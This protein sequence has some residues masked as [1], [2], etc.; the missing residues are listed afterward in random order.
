MNQVIVL[1][2]ADDT[3]VLPAGNVINL[4][5]GGDGFNDFFGPGMAG[6]A[7][8]AGAAETASG[9]TWTDLTT[10]VEQ[11]TVPFLNDTI[12]LPGSN[13]TFVY[14]SGLSSGNVTN[15][16]FFGGGENDFFGSVFPQ[17][18]TAWSDSAVAAGNAD[19][20]LSIPTES[21]PTDATVLT[22]SADTIVFPLFNTINFP[23][24]GVGENNFFGGG[25]GGDGGVGTGIGAGSS[26]AATA[27]ETAAATSATGTA[28]NTL[29]LSADPSA[30]TAT[31]DTFSPGAGE[32]IF[33]PSYN[34]VNLPF[35][36][37]GENDFFGG[38]DGG[39]GGNGTGIGTGGIGSGDTAGTGIGIGGAGGD[40]GN[41]AQFFPVHV[42]FTDSSGTGATISADSS[43]ATSDTSA[44]SL[45]S[46]L[47]G[48]L[49]SSGSSSVGVA[50]GTGIGIGGPGGDGG[51]GAE[52]LPVNL[53]VNTADLGAAHT[54][55]LDTFLDGLSGGS[56][57]GAD[58]A[59]GSLVSSAL[60]G[61]TSVSIDGVGGAGGDAAQ[62]IPIYLD[63]ADSSGAHSVEVTPTELLD[64]LVV[65]GVLG[66]GAT[67]SAAFPT[68]IA[69]DLSSIATEFGSFSG[70]GASDFGAT[71]GPDLAAIMAD[72]GSLL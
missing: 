58:S 26:S 29:G 20:A 7:G 34:T 65:S 1:P 15:L 59:F 2:G 48:I 72:F 5:F 45:D 4:P 53:D 27:G 66:S 30:T 32:T 55:A 38:G 22:G 57:S 49:G 28:D 10:P 11:F 71:L 54:A 68:S 64:S 43:G 46:F 44:G 6:V 9:G 21:L 40:G 62:F 33:F 16:P 13:D 25:N 67:D 14:L 37:V 35:G 61:N 39:V 8:G 69:A 18:G 36:G 41:G 50:T 60:D 56:T 52:I 63:W 3:V 51:N 17:S 24:G 19:S 42:D 47:S 12:V 31:G 70:L 23:F